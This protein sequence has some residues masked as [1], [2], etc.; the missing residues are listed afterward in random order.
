LLVGSL[1][2][3][4]A[5]GFAGGRQ[6]GR[7]VPAAVALERPA[8]LDDDITADAVGEKIQ[9]E[10]GIAA[11]YKAPNTLNLELIRPLFNSI[12]LESADYILGSL[13]VPDYE[14][15]FDAHV[16]V[17]RDGWIMAYYL[18]SAPT[19]K[20]VDVKAKNLDSSRLKT[21]MNNVAVTGGAPFGAVTYYNFNYPNATHMLLVGEYAEEFH[22]TMPSTYSY[23]ELS[24]SVDGYMYIDGQRY[25]YGDMAYDY[26]TI[27][28]T[29]F[30]P[31]IVH[32]VDP[33]GASYSALVVV[34]RMP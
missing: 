25:G 33:W 6:L 3:V 21:V 1:V 11:Y 2:L 34:Y 9:D 4:A 26:A 30:L 7:D 5:V 12:E 28:L 24:W 16:Y 8:F 29:S 13:S 17:R 32:T 18:A 31:D 14:E 20:L 23:Y 15:H 27:P 19:S 22:F 10:A